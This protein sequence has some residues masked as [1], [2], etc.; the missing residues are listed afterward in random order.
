MSKK[1]V[2]LQAELSER[3][4]AK[5]EQSATKILI[6]LSEKELHYFTEYSMKVFL[7]DRKVLQVL[8]VPQVPL[9]ETKWQLTIK[10]KA[11]YQFMEATAI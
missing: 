10:T 9:K 2:F 11:L 5:A 3:D 7:R 4:L 8:K 6:F 1:Y